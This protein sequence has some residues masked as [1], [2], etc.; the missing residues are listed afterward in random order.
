MNR[1]HLMIFIA[2]HCSFALPCLKA[3][4]NKH[5]LSGVIVDSLTQKPGEYFTVTL[6]KENVP[7]KSAVSD[8]QEKFTHVS[9]AARTF[10]SKIVNV[11]FRISGDVPYPMACRIE[12]PKVPL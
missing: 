11:N 12:V 1:H 3:Q 2:L 9:R 7:F 10:T 8:Q 4:E 5:Q 6:K